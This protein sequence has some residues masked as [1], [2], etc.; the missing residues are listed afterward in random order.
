M[1]EV[2]RVCAWNLRIGLQAKE[3]SGIETKCLVDLD[4]RGQIREVCVCRKQEVGGPV[5]LGCV[6]D[7]RRSS[8]RV[9]KEAL[10]KAGR[11]EH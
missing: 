2:E 11:K 10:I 4:M 7:V 5:V 3:M 9:L 6:R 8:N 1:A